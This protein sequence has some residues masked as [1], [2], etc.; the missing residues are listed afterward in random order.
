MLLFE[1]Y[2]SLKE[3]NVLSNPKQTDHALFVKVHQLGSC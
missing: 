2:I 1:R 3:T